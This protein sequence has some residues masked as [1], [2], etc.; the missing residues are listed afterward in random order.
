MT[1]AELTTAQTLGAFYEELADEGFDAEW[2]DGVVAIAARQIIADEGLIVG[3]YEDEDDPDEEDAE[4]EDDT[5]IQF[6]LQ[7][8]VIPDTET[9]E[10]WFGTTDRFGYGRFGYGR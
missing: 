4:D 1:M 9:L 8:T 3:E 10:K 2:I 6:P 7:N 5:V